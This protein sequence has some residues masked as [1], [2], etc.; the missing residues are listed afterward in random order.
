MVESRSLD[1]GKLYPR[2]IAERPS[3]S[4]NAVELFCNKYAAVSR[5]ISSVSC[6]GDS[7][8]V[9]LPVGGLLDGELLAGGLLGGGLLSS[10]LPVVTPLPLLPRAAVP[11][12]LV[13]M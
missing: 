1:G 8:G 10:E 9:P 13:P 5:A 7:V 11:A 6:I 4:N 3:S 2:S 12:A